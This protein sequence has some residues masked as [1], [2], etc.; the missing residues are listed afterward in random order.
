MPISRDQRGWAS[1]FQPHDVCVLTTATKLAD[2]AYPSR[3]IQKAKETS[4]TTSAN[5][6]P[7]SCADHGRGLGLT[8][9]QVSVRTGETMFRI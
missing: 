8:Q 9:T 7:I 3:A 4:P 6:A 5:S 2:A 1:K